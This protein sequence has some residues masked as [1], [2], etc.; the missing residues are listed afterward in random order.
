[1]DYRFNNKFAKHLEA[2]AQEYLASKDLY[3]P[4]VTM[5]PDQYCIAD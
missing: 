5:V 3:H 1:M 2:K 4:M